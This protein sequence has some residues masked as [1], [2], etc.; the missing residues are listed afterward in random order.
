M[1][2]QDN[3]YYVTT[4]IY[5]LN[6]KPHIG[7]AYTTI[8][9]DTLARFYRLIGKDVFFLT[10][11]DEHGQ[12]VERSAQQLGV[13]PQT[14]VDGLAADF[15][16]LWQL[17]G[18]THNDFIRTSEP[19]HKEIVQRIFR[20]LYEQGDIYKKDYQG[21]YCVPCEAH[22]TER[23]LV[24]GKYCPDCGREVEWVSEESYFFRASKYADR[25]LQHI[26]ENPGFI[27]P[28][29]RANEMVNNFL[30]PGLTDL[31]VT[32]TG[33]AW[34]IPVDF[35]P[36]HTIY[37]WIDALTNY[38]TV[39]G[40]TNEDDSLFQK[41]WPA[42]LHLVGKE[43]TRFHTIIWPIILMALG[44][45]LPKQVFGHGWLLF[46]NDKMSKSKGNIVDPLVVIEEFGPDPLRY[47]L[48]AKVQLGNDASYTDELFTRTFN[49]DL[50]NDL[51]NLLHRTLSMM[52]RFSEGT[53]RAAG[54]LEDVDRELQQ[55]AL[56]TPVTIQG[57]LD[58]MDPAGAMAAIWKLVGRCNKYIDEVAP[59][60][61]NR[62]GKEE[63]LATV[64]YQL[65]ESLRFIATCLQ[66]F[67]PHT[68]PRMLAQ[69]G[70]EQNPELYTW[71]SLGAFGLFPTGEVAFSPEPLFPRRE[72]DTE[73]APATETTHHKGEITMTTP[74]SS[75]PEATIAEETAEVA[76]PNP[77]GLKPQITIDDFAKIDF[78]I[79]EVIA[80]EKVPKADRLLQLTLRVGE[81]TRTIVSGIAEHYTPEE[82][83]GKLICIVANL[84]PAK[85]R[86]VESHGML[87]AA[88]DDDHTQV[89]VLEPGKPI[90]SG[91][92]VK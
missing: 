2:R 76:N 55:L 78:R 32:R 49:V 66:P 86:G 34:G 35:D 21:H 90:A 38:L 5:Y 82:L 62:E 65:L 63:R 89:I 64:M 41:F 30:K 88:S 50:A 46:D 67:L 25:L 74:E 42:N 7:H 92:K 22:W 44:L 52:N 1:P 26:E 12:K 29:S 16:A 53:V 56:E 27:Q 68:A 75:A 23:Q 45:P 11:S 24:D 81:T 19:R 18:I 72:V 8:V 73:E 91:S 83:I 43:I 15:N 61:L 28:V 71:N 31:S 69:L 9:A 33:V 3:A 57:C 13:S 10:G 85:I 20:T 40:Y 59:W 84:A 36:D 77:L 58:A 80:C 87:L 48:L 4:P 39:L 6:G 79:A 47:Y 60:A 14:Y 54:V 17:L 70:L 51:G 37:V